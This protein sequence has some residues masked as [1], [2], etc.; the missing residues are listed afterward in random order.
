MLDVDDLLCPRKRHGAILALRLPH[1]QIEPYEAIA[2]DEGRVSTYA[3]GR[4]GC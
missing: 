4:Q 3:H 1:N 2:L